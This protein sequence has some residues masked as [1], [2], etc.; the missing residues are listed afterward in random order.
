MQEQDAGDQMLLLPSPQ[1]ALC[2]CAAG[3]CSQA[4]DQRWEPPPHLCVDFQG[5]QLAAPRHSPGWGR[6]SDLGVSFG[7][8]GS[9]TLLLALGDPNVEV[10]AVLIAVA[11][12]LGDGGLQAS[13][14]EVRGLQGPC[15]QWEGLV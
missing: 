14:L 1:P 9:Q 2:P 3:T 11:V 6:D 4:G 7:D 15:R 13:L 5:V 10:E 12:V 8:H